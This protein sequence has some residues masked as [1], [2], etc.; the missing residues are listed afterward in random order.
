M[1]AHSESQKPT[2]PGCDVF[3]P[4]SLT[5]EEAVKQILAAISKP[6]QGKRVK[7][8]KSFGRV[9]SEDI[10]ALSDVPNHTNSAMDGFAINGRE[11]D[12]DGLSRL[13]VIGTAYAGKPFTGEVNPGEAVK[14]MTGAVMPANTDTV[15]MQEY[16]ELESDVMRIRKAAKTGQ[17]VRQAGED[18]CKGS[19]VLKAGKRINAA[20]LGLLASLGYS[21]VS[22]YKKPRVAFFSNGDEI[23]Q[24]GESLKIGELYDSNRHTL[25]AM[26]KNAGVKGIDLGV[27]GDDYKAI[28][29]LIQKGDKI[30]DMVVT[31]AGASVGE[32]DY[33]YDILSELGKVNIWKIAIKPGRP[34]AFGVLKNSTFFGLPGNP[35]SVMTSFATCI[36]PALEKLSGQETSTPI[37]LK[38]KTNSDIRKRPGRNEFQRGLAYNDPQ[39][40]LCVDVRK[41]Q[42]SGV[43]SSMAEGNCFVSLGINSSGAKSGDKVDIILF[44]ELF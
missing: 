26:L 44:S 6:T 18:I 30:A 22:V 41:Y 10:H 7:L 25:Y 4:G 27:V 9:L 21:K 43:L 24:V 38:A 40:E 17:N 33:I 12:A 11:L 19:I 3:D 20:N 2:G 35:V 29:K 23:R 8:R 42:G 28:K 39:G 34:L 15:V 1:N 14:I 31:S 32:A 5:L 13:R 16:V 36:K 37:Q